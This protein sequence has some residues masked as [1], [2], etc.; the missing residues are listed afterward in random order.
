MAGTLIEVLRAFMIISRW[1]F[2]PRIRNV[3]DKI[4]IEKQN[5]HF[6]KTVPFWDNVEEYVTARQAT[7]DNKIR[8]KST[9][10][11]LTKT[12][13]THSEYVILIAFPLQ[14][15]SHERASM[16]RLYVHCLSSWPIFRSV[17]V[18]VP[19]ETK[20][21]MQNFV[22]SFFKFRSHLQVKTV[23]YLLNES[24]PSFGKHPLGLVKESYT[25]SHKSPETENSRTQPLPYSRTV[26]GALRPFKCSVYSCGGLEL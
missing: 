1:F 14:Q 24:V 10:W 22:G 5:S 13:D 25:Q 4:C 2:F 7:D 19:L 16:L 15:W 8:R 18:S 9:T 26:C 21:N 12:T 3:F 6:P 17:Q 11:L 20:F 23:F